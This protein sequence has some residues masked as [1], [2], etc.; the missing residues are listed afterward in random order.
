M[1]IFSCVSE[2]VGYSKCMKTT[3]QTVKNETIDLGNNERESHGVFEQ[4]DGTFLALTGY[5]SKEFKTRKGAE[6]WYL[7]RTGRA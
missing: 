1:S 7:R 4:R 6:R 3:T 5:F 2:T